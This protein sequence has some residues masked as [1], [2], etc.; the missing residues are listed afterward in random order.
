M[1]VVGREWNINGEDGLYIYPSFPAHFHP[2]TRT[3]TV[4]RYSFSRVTHL[5]LLENAIFPSQRQEPMDKSINSQVFQSFFITFV[6]VSLS[7]CALQPFR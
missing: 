5:T 2:H 3:L 4:P 7:V 6:R 1:M